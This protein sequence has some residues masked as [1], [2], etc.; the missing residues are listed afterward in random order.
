LSSRSPRRHRAWGNGFAYDDGPI[1][2]E[3]ARVHSLGEWWKLF[4]TTYWPP[5]FGSSLY[6]PL[7]TVLFAVQ[8]ALGGGAPWVFH[9]AS[10]LLYAAASAAVLALFA[11][12]LPIGA[13]LAGA[14]LFAVHPVHVEA[15][16][17]VVGQAELLV[18]IAVVFAVR[19][20]VRSRRDGG[21]PAVLTIAACFA[22]G[23]L[24]KEHAIVLP[25]VL[26]V[27]ELLVVR[28][29]ARWRSR[30]RVVGPLAVA[31]IVVAGIY[32]AIRQAV[33]GGVVGE[34]PIV[35]ME[36]ATRFWTFLRVIPEWVRLL[37]WPAHLSADYS[38]PG[39]PVINEPSL[40]IL[41]GAL[42]LVG[43][44]GLAVA[45]WRRSRIGTLGVLWAVIAL[46]PVSNLLAVTGILLAERTM[47]LASV[48]VALSL[49][50]VVAALTTPRWVRPTAV[51]VACLTVLGLV[52]SA[53]RQP[54]WRNDATLFAR[55]AEDAPMGYRAQYLYGQTQF[56]QGKAAEGERRLRLAIRLNPN[57]ADVDAMNFLATKYRESHLCPQALP[58]YRQA[59]ER[60]PERPDV[61]FGL[62]WCLLETGDPGGAR[63]EAQRG[64]AA[65]QLRGYFLAV[66][67]KADS[68]TR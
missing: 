5:R 54:V 20:Y 21:R 43:A 27:V 19:A 50:A 9:V 8:W 33:V 25:L 31:L 1:I 18:A 14:A 37:L 58:L 35:A 55:T 46:A 13:A 12:L 30:L 2:V 38:P 53:R 41:P 10:V 6:R 51:V 44:I 61:R 45:L 48:G 60:A 16:A 26:A 4:A 68:L 24:A 47:F 11:E 65:G 67:A 15:V 34:Q 36:G 23:L 56:A 57:P 39:L 42:L 3:N 22:G 40:E 66:I 52:K 64:L 49:G 32:L 28:D 17:N 63:A 59:V 62:S 7:T 29:P